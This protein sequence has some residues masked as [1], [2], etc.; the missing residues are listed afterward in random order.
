MSCNT[1]SLH[2][3]SQLLTPVLDSHSKALRHLEQ[4]LCA[5]PPFVYPAFKRECPHLKQAFLT[6]HELCG[7]A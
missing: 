7:A 4:L 3:P 5:L 1:Y 6:G 2:G